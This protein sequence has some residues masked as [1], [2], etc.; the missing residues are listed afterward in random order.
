M[1]RI[2]IFI[3]KQRAFLIAAMR[4]A[5]LGLA[6]ISLLFSCLLLLNYYQLSTQDPLNS[7][8]LNVMMKKMKADPQNQDLRDQVRAM[9]LLARKAFFVGTRQL[10]TGGCI[11]LGTL[12][13]LLVCLKG[14]ASLRSGLPDPGPLESN[15]DDWSRLT[16]ERRGVAVSSMVILALSLAAGWLSND[17]LQDDEVFA[18]ATSRNPSSEDF[19]RNWA[20]FRGPGGNGVATVQSAPNRWDGATGDGITWKV[21]VPL[22]GYSSPV[23]WEDRLFVTGA[24]EKQREIYCYQSSTGKI[25][26]RKSVASNA[27]EP[28]IHRDT[29][30]AAPSTATDGRFVSAIFAT[31]DLICLDM[32]GEEVW[33]KSLSLP[34][35]HYGHSSSLMI[36][37]DLLLVQYDQNEDARLVALELSTGRQVWRVER[38]HISW[39]SPICVNTG[40]RWELILTDNAAVTSYDPRTGALLWRNECLGGEMGPSAAY[41]GGRVAVA[42]DYA[43]CA[44]L[45]LAAKEPVILWEYE[46]NLPDTAS[47]LL[48]ENYLFLATSR[49]VLVCLDAKTGKKYWEHECSDG[50]Y[51]S[52]ILV[53]DL[54]YAMDLRGVM[55]IFKA[56]STFAS[57]AESNLGEPSACTPAVLEE[58]I[59]LRGD[60]YLYFV[61]G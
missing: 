6:A 61:A 41:A 58:G 32:N 49:G 24:D 22:P 13:V 4:G 25:L 16:R 57:V 18:A 53:G 21:E 2:R 7:P 50:F 5:V 36:F 56:D 29:G 45:N 48:T 46:E 8:A 55:H 1:K 19:L 37:D 9:D 33:K 54:V 34:D 10:R 11:L 39:S 30:Y 44:V 12:I 15:P 60:R 42:N 40:E 17:H 52:P 23:I 35:N 28:T 27:D 38:T 3:E 20:A 51:S 43:V 59:Y 31:G 14:L 26:W 47:P